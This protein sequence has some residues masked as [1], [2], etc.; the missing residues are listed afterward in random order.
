MNPV[1]RVSAR[2]AGVLLFAALACALAALVL[3]VTPASAHAQ[4][5]STDPENGAEFTVAPET[6]TLVFSEAVTVSAGGMR[7]FSSE[8]EPEELPA[9]VSGH[10]VS[11]VLPATMPDGRYVIGW[12]VTS[13]DGHPITGTIGFS[14]GDAA[15]V[16]AV[17]VPNSAVQDADLN[18]AIAAVTVMHY[19]GMLL[20]LG[21]LVFDRLVLRRH[22]VTLMPRTVRVAAGIAVLA[23]AALVPLAALR[24]LGLPASDILLPGEWLP[25]VTWQPLAVVTVTTIGLLPSV[26]ARHPRASAIAAVG[27]ALAV[28]APILTGHSSTKQPLW[29]MVV[30][31]GVHLIAAAIWLGGLLCLGV[32]LRQSGARAADGSRLTDASVAAH[33]VR[34]FSTVAALS[35]I[36]LMISGTVMATIILGDLALV[37]AT[38]YGRTFLIKV[39]LVAVAVGIAAYNRYRLV[40]AI[41]RSPSA[42]GG[43]LRLRS[44]VAR[45]I[46]VIGAALI[47]TG[48]LVGLSPAGHTTHEASAA[49]AAPVVTSIEQTSSGLTVTGDITATIEGGEL[50]FSL[51]DE[52]GDSVLPQELPTVSSRL[53]ARDLGPFDAVVESTGVPGEYTAAVDTPFAGE[54]QLVITT[55]VSRFESVTVTTTVTMGDA[56]VLD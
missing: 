43:W 48:I 30:G 40:P 46:A 12:R 34:R 2:R 3:I 45:E 26:A 23:A 41:R 38:G 50:I 53:P 39:G 9:S 29:L 36:A 20:V 7:L 51:T 13:A 11:A 35:A 6:A 22:D 4:L 31:D 37:V 49:P 17:A 16:A 15:G 5:V 8:G 1:L 18:A 44:T 19:L 25:A 32:F 10:N 21:M 27:A 55:R 54:W 33:V 52:Q 47:A 14:V 56:G 24:T 28:L 42:N